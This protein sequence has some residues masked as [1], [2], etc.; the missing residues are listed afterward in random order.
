MKNIIFIA[1]PAAGKGTQAKMFSLEYNIPHISTGDLL[2]DEVTSGSELGKALKH[3][4]DIGNLISDDVIVN[5]LRKR[6]CRV[7]CNNGYVLDGFPR[8]LDQAITYDNLV[9]E[10]GKEVGVVVH[11]H[12]DKEITLKRTL[13]RMIC[14]TCGT[15]YN[16][17]VPELKPII[18]GIC[19]KCGHTLKQRSDDNL[20]TFNNRYNTYINAT[21]PLIEYYQ[22][23]GILKIMKIN[24]SD[25]VNDI[26]NKVKELIN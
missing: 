18:E 17:A 19:N 26:F 16:M 24:E 6:I 2:R 14:G 21:K 23:K 13:N 1:P 22:N 10:L 4:M 15:S 5:L 9:R 7:D 3:E 25:T 20:E 12:I 8:N 11:L